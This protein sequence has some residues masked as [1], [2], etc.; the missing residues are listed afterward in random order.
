MV[1]LSL[2]MRLLAMDFDG[3]IAD[4]ILECAV[5]GPYCLYKE[6]EGL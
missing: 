5:A 6:F 3:V 1:R 2:H 4:S